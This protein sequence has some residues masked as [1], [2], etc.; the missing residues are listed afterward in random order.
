LHVYNCT[1]AGDY[2]T[3][4]YDLCPSQAEELNATVL[5]FILLE[6]HES[7]THIEDMRLIALVYLNH[8]VVV[9]VVVVDVVAVEAVLFSLACHVRL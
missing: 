3:E 2:S 7:V 1:I 4:K 8:L 9:V 5:G 6:L